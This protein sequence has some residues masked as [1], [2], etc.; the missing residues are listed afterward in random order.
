MATQLIQLK[1][2]MLVEAEMPGRTGE[3][4]AGGV[5]KLAVSFDEKVKPLL[6]D[7]CTPLG[8][9]WQELNQSMHVEQAEVEIGLSFEGEGNL[10][11]TKAKTGA[12]F[13]VNGLLSGAGGERTSPANVPYPTLALTGDAYDASSGGTYAAANPEY[14]V[15]DTPTDHQ[16]G[17]PGHLQDLFPFGSG[18]YVAVGDHR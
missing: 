1:N 9:V 7:I 10:F 15:T 11:V 16:A 17:R 12:N 4:I 8:E 6:L 13:T 5:N 14:S 2:G 18:G 3:Q